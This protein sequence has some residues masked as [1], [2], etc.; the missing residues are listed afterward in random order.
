MDDLFDKLKAVVELL[1]RTPVRPGEHL[2]GAVDQAA[3]VGVGYSDAVD[4]A[5]RTQ[6]ARWQVLDW[7]SWAL[8]LSVGVVL[9]TALAV[10][11][12]EAVST[13]PAA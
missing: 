7:V 11:V 9:V 6:A 5:L 13:G 2:G 4:E 3:V 12:P 1:L 10:R 8:T